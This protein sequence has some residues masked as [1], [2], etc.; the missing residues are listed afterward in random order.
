MLDLLTTTAPVPTTK[1]ASV[2]DQLLGEQQL[3][4]GET[5]EQRWFRSLDIHKARV[6]CA[7]L[8]R[9]ISQTG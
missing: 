3:S 2:G 4:E 9:D 7:Q 8:G 5:E 1:A 6:L